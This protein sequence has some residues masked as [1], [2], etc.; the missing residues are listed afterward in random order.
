[1]KYEDRHKASNCDL[2]RGKEGCREGKKDITEKEGQNINYTQ[3]KRSPG[4]AA[5]TLTNLR[6]HSSNMAWETEKSLSAF[7]LLLGLKQSEIH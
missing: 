5:V 1:M 4:K 7:F 6:K 3:E 2:Q